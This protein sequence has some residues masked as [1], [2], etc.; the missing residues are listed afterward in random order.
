[1]EFLARRRCN[2]PPRPRSAAISRMRPKP[3]TPLNARNTR[4]TLTKWS[5]VFANNHGRLISNTMWLTRIPIKRSSTTA[6]VASVSGKPSRRI[7]QMRS[8]SPPRKETKV[9][10]KNIPSRV[11]RKDSE[12]R[13][14][15]PNRETT[16]TNRSAVRNDCPNATARAAST[17]QGE[18]VERVLIRT[19]M[20]SC[21]AIR[22][23][24]SSVIPTLITNPKRPFGFAAWSSESVMLCRPRELRSPAVTKIS[25]NRPMRQSKE[26]PHRQDE[27]TWAL[28]RAD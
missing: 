20:S 9:W 27:R 15:A 3:P 28:R 14:R 12:N 26:L 10:L 24:M 4:T 21:H 16:R 19:L 22:P 8:A 1:M 7:R 6:E 2:S 5:V 17:A 13:K 25:T 23:K 18:I 11:T